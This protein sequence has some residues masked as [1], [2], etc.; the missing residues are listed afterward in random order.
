[1]PQTRCLNR[2][3]S[4][5]FEIKTGNARSECWQVWFRLRPFSL[6][7]RESLLTVSSCGSCLCTH[8]HIRKRVHCWRPFPFLYGH[9][10][11]WIRAH[12]M[13]SFNLS[14]LLKSPISKYGHIGD[15]RFNLSLEAHNS[16]HNGNYRYSQGSPWFCPRSKQK[17]SQ[18]RQFW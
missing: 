7:C 18:L 2:S 10:L 9:Q 13:T 6:V 5:S 12:L 16:V 15:Q 3:L 11:Y 8:T 4:H 14:Y 17:D 1:M